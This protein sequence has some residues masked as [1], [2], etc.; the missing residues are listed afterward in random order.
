MKRPQLKEIPV[1]QQTIT[2]FGG[3]NH[4][5][6]IGDNEWYDMQNM[7]PDDTPVLS[8]RRPRGYLRE[9]TGLQGLYARDTLYYIH[10]GYLYKGGKRIDLSTAGIDRFGGG[11]RTLISM[12]AY[13]V[14]FPDKIRY[15][16]STGTASSLENYISCTGEIHFDPCRLEDGNAD[17]IYPERSDTAPANPT[18]G[19]YWLDTS[20]N[21]LKQY[22]SDTGQWVS[23]P[24]TYVKISATGIGIGFAVYDGVKI[25]G[26]PEEY[27]S[28]NG[29]TI[30]WGVGDDYII[31]VGLTGNTKLTSG[32]IRVERTVPGM[33]FVTE[34][35]NRLWGCSSDSHEIYACKL[36][37]PTN[38][39]CFMGISTDS[40]SATIGT[41]GDFTGACSHLGYVLFFKEDVIHKVYGNKPANYQ[42]STVNARG[43]QKGCHHSL[44][45]VSE[46]L[47][48]KATVGVCAY[49]GGLPA[50]ISENM[51]STAYSQAAAG[52]YGSR[53]AISMKDSAGKWNLFTYDTLTG[54]WHRQDHTHATAFARLG[55]ELYY[56][57]DIGGGK[58]RLC[59]MGGSLAY[60]P[61]GS[62][63]AAAHT[64]GPVPWYVETGSIETDV[65]DHLTLRRLQ[66]RLSVETDAR[67]RILLR[68]DTDTLW[69]PVYSVRASDRRAV[70]VPLI[71]RRCERLRLRIEG[72][73]M[74]HILAL[75][76]IMEEGSERS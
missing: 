6:K 76:K 7:A 19:M 49:Q 50:S 58:G 25:S 38:W 2:T 71:P 45:T 36:G 48:Y 31:V 21:V 32:S 26:L 74:A 1:K 33:D 10:D 68:Y 14:I 11:E 43:V 24:T 20:N 53:Y 62:P 40:Y 72:T 52:V 44:A 70:T 30:L 13:L 60:E 17:A 47:Y 42:V 75:N 69:Q 8:P 64:E 73:G 51:G 3:Y 22:A 34:Q 18:G 37:D 27:E 63:P 66:L 67:V 56:V 65:P 29:D 15:N 28:L 61:G 41:P 46:V 54:L 59:S 55:D 39:N 35:D 4:Q 12:G 16:T 5:Y 57:E 9:I 23:V